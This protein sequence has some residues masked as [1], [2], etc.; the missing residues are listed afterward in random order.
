LVPLA[1][2]RLVKRA[3]RD[4]GS[5]AAVEA[6]VGDLDGER[7]QA[8]VVLW[9]RG[10]VYRLRDAAAMAQSD[11]RDA[12]VRAGLADDDWRQRLDAE[13]GV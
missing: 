13:L 11:W 9:A 8:A 3:Q 2:D 10:D 5:T 1:S 4:F 7:L 6:V 12:L